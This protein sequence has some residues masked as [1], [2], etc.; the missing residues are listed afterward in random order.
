VWEVSRRP[1]RVVIATLGANVGA[2]EVDAELGELSEEA[3]GGEGAGGG[4]DV[5]RTNELAGGAIEAT[6]DDEIAVVVAN[7]FEGSG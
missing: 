7:I 5:E 2:G 6:G 3:S 1:S 4:K